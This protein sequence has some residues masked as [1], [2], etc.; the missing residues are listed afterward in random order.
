MIINAALV[1]V[2]ERA[3]NPHG[4]RIKDFTVT[5]CN[6]VFLGGQPCQHAVNFQDFR[7]LFCL[8]V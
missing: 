4:K 2:Q 5:K 7:D 1:K 8:C 6:E 3:S